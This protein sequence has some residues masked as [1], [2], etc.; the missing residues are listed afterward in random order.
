[1]WINWIKMTSFR[2]ANFLC[3]LMTFGIA[4]EYQEKNI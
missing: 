3:F 1:M 2:L 4:Q